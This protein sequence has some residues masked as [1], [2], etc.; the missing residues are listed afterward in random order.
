MR[1]KRDFEKGILV[2]NQHD[3]GLDFRLS[4]PSNKTLIDDLLS[5]QICEIELFYKICFH[6]LHLSDYNIHFPL[7]L[8]CQMIKQMIHD[9]E[10]NLIG[11]FKV[12]FDLGCKTLLFNPC[13]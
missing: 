11:I 13:Q 6:P 3:F 2:V 8:N 5:A 9:G 10:R 7:W 4:I 1:V 12:N